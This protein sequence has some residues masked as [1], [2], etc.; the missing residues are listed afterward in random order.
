ME[1]PDNA[2]NRKDQSNSNGNG[3]IRP[4]STRNQRNPLDPS[5]TAKARCRRVASV[6]RSRKGK[7]STHSRS[8]FQAVRRSTC[9]RHP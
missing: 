6:L 1:R 8:S 4:G 7:C 2:E 3:E 5:W 9:P